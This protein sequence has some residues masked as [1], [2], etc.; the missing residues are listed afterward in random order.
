MLAQSGRGLLTADH[1]NAEQKVNPVSGEPDKNHTLNL[2]P[3]CI[4][5]PD[6]FDDRKWNDTTNLR[7]LVYDATEMDKNGILS[8]PAKCRCWM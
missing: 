7:R 8:V 3:L 4:E 1:G 5:N 2:V 6:V